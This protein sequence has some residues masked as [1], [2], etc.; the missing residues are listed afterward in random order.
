MTIQKVNIARI[1]ISELEE[2]EKRAL[3]R[4]LM[5]TR[6]EVKTK[7]E[8]SEGKLDPDTGLPYEDTDS[9]PK[10]N[11]YAYWE[12]Y[13]D[14]KMNIPYNKDYVGALEKSEYYMKS[15]QQPSTVV[16]RAGNPTPIKGWDKSALIIQGGI[17]E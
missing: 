10:D 1:E 16:D 15:T 4:P 12:K 13:Y 5:K 14:D 17:I 8:K 3:L 6:E 7:S 2:G 11:N 9:I